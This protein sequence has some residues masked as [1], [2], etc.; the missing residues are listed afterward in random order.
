M[1]EDHSQAR[2]AE[3]ILEV[4]LKLFWQWCILEYE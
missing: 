2:I 1:I 4:S 3:V